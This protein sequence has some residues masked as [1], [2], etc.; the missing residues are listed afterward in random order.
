MEYKPAL[1][2]RKA[3]RAYPYILKLP[4]FMLVLGI[5]DRIVNSNCSTAAQRVSVYT[6]VCI[7][8]GVVEGGCVSFPGEKSSPFFFCPPNFPNCKY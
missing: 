2:L 4:S 5:K 6:W 7:W 3:E 8:G 1:R